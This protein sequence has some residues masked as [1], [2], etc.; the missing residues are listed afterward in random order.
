MKKVFGI[1]LILIIAALIFALI[2]FKGF[3]G[4]GKDSGENKKKDDTSVSETTEKKTEATTEP[5]TEEKTEEKTA[6]VTVSGRDYLF[7][8]E[9]VSLE[10]LAAEIA[11]LDK[12]TKISI[13][14]DDTAAKNTMDDLTDKLDEL[15][16]KNYEKIAK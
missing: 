7:G 2:Y 5:T 3:G 9:K 10:K 1:L 16:Y 8:N 14:Y 13:T 12:E 11:K 15:G 6:S 4:F